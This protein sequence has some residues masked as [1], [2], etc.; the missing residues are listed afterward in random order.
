MTTR[1]VSGARTL[2]YEVTYT[3]GVQTAKKLIR[4]VVAV[5]Q[6]GIEPTRPAR[7]QSAAARYRIAQGDPLLLL[8]GD[9]PQLEQAQRQQSC[10]RNGHSGARYASSAQPE[11]HWP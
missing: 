7:R 5:G 2:T 8:G 4:S 3:D 10:C 9:E 11:T 6:Q 1:G